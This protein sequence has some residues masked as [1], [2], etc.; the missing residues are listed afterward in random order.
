MSRLRHPAAALALLL[1]L[2]LLAAGAPTAGAAVATPHWAITTESSPTYFRPGDTADEY[3][4][5]VRNSGGAG[6][7]APFF[8]HDVLP[9]GVTATGV[10]G[11]VGHSGPVAMGCDIAT[12]TCTANALQPGSGELAIMRITVAVAGG[13]PEEPVTNTAQVSGGGAPEARTAKPTRITTAPVPFGISD[14]SSEATEPSGFPD[15]QAGSHPWELTTRLAFNIKGTGPTEPAPRDADI[16]LPPG[17]FGNLRGIPQCPQ[18]QFLHGN[19][20]NACPPDTDVG[21]IV[22]F[23]YGG[24]E[25]QEEPVFNI[26]P[27]PGQPAELG[28]T[29]AG[30]VHIPILFHLRS[31][32]DYGLT[33]QVSGISE[34]Q[35]VQ[36]AQVT[37]W[38]V[39]ADPSHN[40]ER[41]GL[42]GTG[43]GCSQGCA[44]EAAPT[45]V[46][47]LPTSCPGRPLS[48]DLLSDSW[49]N[50]G[51]FLSPPPS[52]SPPITGCDRLAFDPA[53]AIG[54][55]SARASNPSGYTADLKVPQNEE[56]EGL[57]TAH[58]QTAV[59]TLPEGV[60][61]SPS[62][63]NGLIG[64]PQSGAEAINLHSTLAPNCPDASKLGTVEVETPALEHPLKGSLFLAQQG[65]AGPQQGSN[66]F[67]TLLALYLVA[68]G[69]GVVVKLA[70][71]VSANPLTGQLTA[72][73]DDNPQVPFSDL[74]LSF[75]GGPGAALSNPA[76][77]GTYTT[78]AQL[79]PWSSSTPITR[80]S[81]FQ[82]TSGSDGGPCP[83]DPTLAPSFT[84]GTQSNQASAYSPFSLTFSRGDG[85]DEFSS[86]SQTF[87]KGV[88]GR[89]AGV[90][91]C[92]E[93]ELAGRACSAASRIGSVTVAAGPGPAP[94]YVHGSVY[95][96]GPYRGAPFG[97]AVIVPAIAGPFNLGTVLVRGAITFDPNSA[98]ASV[99]SDPFPSILQGIPLQ[100]RS[101]NVLLDR[102]GFMFNPTSCLPM[103]VTG[104][105]TGTH[106]TSAAVSS[107]FQAA[108]CARLPFKPTFQASTSG[109]T[110]KKLGA[111]LHVK[112]VPPHEGPQSSSSGGTTGSASGTSGT[113]GSASG[114]SA[115]TEEANI[116]RV[117][118]DLP[119]QLPSRLTTLQKA[120]T[121]KHFKAN[122]TN[123]PKA[124]KISQTASITPILPVPLEGPA[125]FVS[126]GGEAFPSLIIV[127]QGYGVTIDLVGST[128]ISKAGITSSTFKA[129]P[130]QPVGSFELTLP[131]GKYS[132]LAANGNLCKTK[133]TMPTE[134]VAQ[135]GLAIHQTT[136]IRVTGCGKTKRAKKGRH[137][138]RTK[139]R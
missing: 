19:G 124:S 35:I 98:Q 81:S 57:A 41:R 62:A 1:L 70:G 90:P 102:E 92:S 120:C 77:C 106:G 2:A 84:A 99:L 135:N 6:T 122:P 75:F 37:L 63:A 29:Y 11:S 36:A 20:E 26:A 76:S 13:I 113:S 95:L 115:Q 58:L 117:K 43:V 47:T 7:N 65:N 96:T 69:S 101:V 129:V 5:V 38:G 60:V 114:S 14:F 50:P 71:Q 16:A 116:A 17:V 33:A 110:N 131:E 100:V 45:P 125:Y 139:R 79:T 61:A 51:E 119:K 97:E 105:I 93:S 104:T 42:G 34:A 53:F 9:P 136:K 85:E 87:P 91:R 44:S 118:V 25:Q 94:V 111:S 3:R 24:A 137:A 52:V 46:L 112:L 10:T 48:V 132:A 74:R 64:C 128:F 133:L 67:A 88:L 78:T 109:K 55:D 83:G 138:K 121:K 12:L 103:A 130:D 15:T 23:F 89:I 22:L 30:F 49:Q 72:T 82:I 134:F 80:L 107:R 66:P 28:F 127:L 31:E 56:P 18:T 123:C 54:P 86:L 39:P 40:S 8:V 73:F 59:I 126:H 32:G 108:N 4:V 21:M 27:S 68:E